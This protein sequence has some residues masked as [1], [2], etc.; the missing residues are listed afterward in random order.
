MSFKSVSFDRKKS[1]F[2]KTL[3]KRVDNYFRE[4]KISKHANFN[5]FLKTILL[6]LLYFGSYSL[7]YVFNASYFSIILWFAMGFG[8]AGIGMSVMHDANHGAY[9]KNKK[10]N[11]FFGFFITFLG[12]NYINWRI[13]HNVLHHT[14]TNISSM[15]EDLDSGVLFRFSPDQKLK[16]HHKYQHLYAWFLYGL[17]TIQWSF[18]K[19]FLQL[20][21]YHKNGLLKIQK[22]NFTNQM[23]LLIFYKV[24]YYAYAL[25]LPLIFL[26]NWWLVLIG[27]FTMHY[28]A[29]LIL[30]I[31]FQCAH[32]MEP[33]DFNSPN[34]SRVVDKNWFVHQL[35][36]TCNFAMN[37][38]LLSWFIGGLNFQIEH[39]LFPNICHIHYKKISKI[40]Q[41][42]AQEFNVPY[43]SYKNMF[44][45]VRSH[46]KFLKHLGSY[47]IA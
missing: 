28:T 25:V 22:R 31:V 15:D 12:G 40:V 27:Y 36:T 24:I 18:E 7:L 9:S 45:A 19:D 29:G 3:K 14:Y 13:Q 26:D 8:M 5:M 10:I 34:E 30:S 46:Y 44:S 1:V 41:S 47:N 35:N 16:K 32:V 43:K 11:N 23:A 6:I 21:R 38:K 17:M 42:T 4:N 20:I 37:S 2:V 33:N 39:H